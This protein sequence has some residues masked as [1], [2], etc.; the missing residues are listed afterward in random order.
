MNGFVKTKKILI[1]T[2]LTVFLLCVSSSVP[3]LVNA[4]EIPVYNGSTLE[5][6]YVFGQKLTLPEATIKYDGYTKRAQVYTTF[7]SGRVVED[8]ILYLTEEG[9]YKVC[10]FAVFDGEQKSVEQKFSVQ[11]K[12]FTV[13]KDTSSVEYATYKAE[14][15]N[16]D[17]LAISGEVSGAYVHLSAGD[18]LTYNKVIDLNGKTSLDSIVR[19]VFTPSVIGV[20]DVGAINV[21]LTDAYNPQNYVTINALGN[22]ENAASYVKVAASNGQVLSGWDYGGNRIFSGTNPFGYAMYCLFN[23]FSAKRPSIDTIDKNYLEFAMD[24]EEKTVHA[25]NNYNKKYSSVIGDLDSADDYGIVWDG[26]TTGECFLSVSC[27]DYVGQ[28]ADFVVQT[29]MGEQVISNDDFVRSSPTLE[30]DYINYDKNDLPKAQVNKPYKLFDLSCKSP[31]F[32]NLKLEQ[33]VYFDYNGLKTP[34]EVSNG[35]FTP[36]QKGEYTVEISVTDALEQSTVE[37]YVVTATDQEMPIFISVVGAQQTSGKAGEFI[38]ICDIETNGGS[39]EIKVEYSVT[40]NDKDIKVT[41]KQFFP[42]N[43]GNY[44]VKV[45]ATDYIGNEKTYEYTVQISPADKPVFTVFPVM[46]KY[47]ISGNEYQLQEIFAKDYITSSNKDVKAEILYQD[48]YGVKRAVNGKIRPIVKNNEDITVINYI[49]KIG[50]A[51]QRLEYQVPTIIVRENNAIQI[52]RLFVANGSNVA[53]SEES[54]VKFRFFDNTSY[55][56]I[57]PLAINGID[58]RFSADAIGSNF[59]KLIVTLTDIYNPNQ[60]IKLNYSLR[61]SKTEFT[62]NNQDTV[63]TTEKVLGRAN[64]VLAFTVDTVNEIV[65]F[66]TTSTKKASI[67][68][69]ANGQEYKGFDSGLVYLNFSFEGVTSVSTFKVNNIS[70]KV[71]ENSGEDF[72]RPKLAILGDFG[73]NYQ[74]GEKVK[75]PKIV[76]T[77]VV[78]GLLSVKMSVTAPN[79]SY[80][81]DESG[82]LLY[83]VENKE[84]S[85][86]LEEYGSYKV[87]LQVVDNDG[88]PY[89]YSFEY[90]VEYDNAPIIKVEKVPTTGKVGKKIVVPAAKIEHSELGGKTTLIT[91]LISDTGNIYKLTDLAFVPQ[92]AGIY[93]IRYY[94]IDE[95]G[96]NSMLN[97][98]IKVS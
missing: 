1:A 21:V 75:L 98:N 96:N 26:F 81:F 36:T 64:S 12:L 42:T 49:A 6:N 31:Y 65:K 4:T 74:P 89:K 90:R 13:Q 15:H 59:E 71:L 69:Y 14:E 60:S 80:V 3:K 39:G 78:D 84:Y 48:A 66:D 19:I 97:F 62:L 95:L 79:D 86:K 18:K 88:N 58:V 45:F 70:G 10:F 43:P 23:G 7:P 85:I 37:T 40:L 72:A 91:Y 33:K 2:L 17:A 28:T 11:K 25:V 83:N 94:C 57:N 46:P 34:V 51:E 87:F 16:K 82:L 41:D 24:Y 68:T 92:R 76:S 93:T 50:D 63:Y 55:D 38:S 29:I 61:G 27:G 77:D 5:Q 32:S 8:S 9:V 54:C 47:L 22:E 35:T 73:G 44:K 53:Y 20:Q 30:I 52:E 67:K 56:F